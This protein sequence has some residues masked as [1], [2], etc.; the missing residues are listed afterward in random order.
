MNW[1]QLISYC[2][3]QPPSLNISIQMFHRNAQIIIPTQ[4]SPVNSFTATLSLGAICVNFSSYIYVYAW[5]HNFNVIVLNRDHNYSTLCSRFAFF[6][7]LFLK[8]AFW[9]GQPLFTFFTKEEY[10]CA[11]WDLLF[12]QFDFSSQKRSTLIGCRLVG[13][14]LVASAS[15]SLHFSNKL[16]S[17]S[18]VW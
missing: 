7:N 18:V 3:P 9:R 13:E 17:F 8:A 5:L 11:C 2:A 6:L 10:C 16:R 4:Y 14:H 1:L 15:R 12:F